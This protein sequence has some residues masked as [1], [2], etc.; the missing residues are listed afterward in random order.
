LKNRKLI[1]LVIFCIIPLCLILLEPLLKNYIADYLAKSTGLGY[2]YQLVDYFLV[3]IFILV[4]ELVIILNYIIFS[5]RW[6]TNKKIILSNFKIKVKRTFKNYPLIFLNIFAVILTLYFFLATNSLN[7]EIIIQDDYSWHYYHSW[8]TIE[9]LIPEFQSTIGFSNYFYA[10][11]PLFT[12]YPPGIYFFI[13]ILAFIGIPI[14]L[15]IRIIVAATIIGFINIIYLLCRKLK[16]SKLS[17]VFGSLTFLIFNEWTYFLNAGQFIFLFSVLLGFIF[18]Y[19]FYDLITTKEDYLHN[20]RT[21]FLVFL[22]TL[23]NFIHYITGLIIYLFMVI[24][25][26]YRSLEKNKIHNSR[27][28]Y[29]VFLFITGFS[30]LNS[31]FFLIP[32]ALSSIQYVADI[33]E[34]IR[35]NIDNATFY[36]GTTYYVNQFIVSL[37]FSVFFFIVYG[38]I[39]ILK[40]NEREFFPF[41]ILLAFLSLFIIILRFLGTYINPQLT[42]ITFDRFFVFIS[43]LGAIVVGKFIDCAKLEALNFQKKHRIFFSIPHSIIIGLF[44]SQIMPPIGPY[45][46][47]DWVSIEDDVKGIY[48]WIEDNGENEFR[49]L[50]EDS[51]FITN[52][53]WGGHSTSLLPTNLNYSFIGGYHSTFRGVFNPIINATSYDGLIFGEEEYNLPKIIS[54]LNDLNIRFMII[55]SEN[56][57]DFFEQNPLYFSSKQ[58]IGRFKI[59]EYKHAVNSYFISTNSLSKFTNEKIS[60]S[61]VVFKLESA[62]KNDVIKISFQKFENWRCYLNG[63]ECDFSSEDTLMR[64]QIPD[65]GDWEIEILWRK[66]DIEIL[67]NIISIISFLSVISI[68]IFYSIK[69]LKG[70]KGNE[71]KPELNQ[72]Q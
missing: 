5:E 46:N 9:H 30:A 62:S 8:F 15:S 37:T 44:I 52:H 57:S 23:I 6:K 65:N 59:F 33:S 70:R 7:L 4:I 61:S 71:F 20:Y 50:L 45:F 55:W 22:L 60:Q 26:L 16:I 25:I 48:E 39:W 41:N 40:K 69:I 18:I 49:I 12:Y 63:T 3:L 35:N 32:S 10:G 68:I 36:V 1:P 34:L 42:V 19:V 17:S 56:L 53:M 11:H 29:Q 38:F 27:S 21:Y 66:T 47:S 13:A 54:R 51:C 24:F 72:S 58:T 67:S 43:T 28:D 14:E 64:I 2:S 31:C